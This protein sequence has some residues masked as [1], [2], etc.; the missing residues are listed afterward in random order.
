MSTRSSKNKTN[1][2]PFLINIP[3]FIFIYKDKSIID[4]DILKEYL[5]KLLHEELDI[6]LQDNFIFHYKKGKKD[7][8][9]LAK[10]L[11]ST[12]VF[13]VL[14]MQKT[15]D[16]FPVEIEHEK[17]LILGKK[18]T[19]LGMLYD[20]FRLQ[21]VFRDMLS[22]QELGFKYLHIVFTKR[23]IATW[24]KGNRRYHART[25]VY[26]F[27]NIISTSG[28]VEA[29]AK[30]RE[31]YVAKKALMTSGMSG[32]L[33]EEELK[34]QFKGR[35][36]DYDDERITEI[37]KGYV[38]Q[39]FFY[40]TTFE[41]FCEDKNCRLYNAH[42]QEEMIHAQLEGKEFCERHEKVLERIRTGDF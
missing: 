37:V 32:D 34:K 29:P 28:L 24:D 22:S 4:W 41:P 19:V 38:M 25:S 7:L 17:D 16:P 8:D 1:Y 27:P 2:S 3:D 26:G 35:F 23:S 31:F 14:D 10:K 36:V 15:Y 11:V 9:F 5:I 18:E 40:H 20:G 21:K 12:K 42:W 6:K 39:A 33:V 13:D 30:P